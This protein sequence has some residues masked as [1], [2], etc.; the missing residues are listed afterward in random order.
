[1]TVSEIS[2][3][4]FRYANISVSYALNDALS[5]FSALCTRCATTGLSIPGWEDT[6]REGS[7]ALG[8]LG[9]KFHLPV[10]A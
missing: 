9:V 5:R 3:L 2:L 7:Q 4:E 1:M 8:T 6:Y 10:M